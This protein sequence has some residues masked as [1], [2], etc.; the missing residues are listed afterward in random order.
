M[1]RSDLRQ[2]R[3]ANLKPTC[4]DMRCVAYGHL[5]RLAMWKL[6][7]EWDREL[8]T[9]DKLARMRRAVDELGGWLLFERTVGAGERRHVQVDTETHNFMPV[10]Y[11]RKVHFEPTPTAFPCV[12]VVP[13]ISMQYFGRSPW[14]AKCLTYTQM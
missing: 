11:P 14:S 13:L 5:V 2:L 4:G 9:V 3:A 6:R 12:C 10:L 8:S 7:N 1:I